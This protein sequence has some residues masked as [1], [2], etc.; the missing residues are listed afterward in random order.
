LSRLLS[1]PAFVAASVVV[2][3]KQEESIS[4][5]GSGDTFHDGSK[6]KDVR[7]SNIVAAKVNLP[8]QNAND[9]KALVSWLL[10]IGR[11]LDS[12]H[13]MVPLSL[14][15]CQCCQNITWTPRNG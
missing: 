15:N 9:S 11:L 5:A 3:Q 2:H 10:I 13:F 8:F 12:Q 7:T 6:G 4:M 14:G 1:L